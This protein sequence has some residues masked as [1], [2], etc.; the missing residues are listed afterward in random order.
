MAVFAALPLLKNSGNE[1]AQ[2]IAV[3]Q[4]SAP[5]AATD[6]S[7]ITRAISHARIVDGSLVT[8]A[9]TP[10]D[11]V[12]TP[13]GVGLEMWLR[14]DEPGSGVGRY[15]EVRWLVAIPA[16][17]TVA[18]DTLVHLEPADVYGVYVPSP[19]VQ[20]L[21][22]AATTTRNEAAASASAAATSATTAGAAR[23]EAVVAKNA[24]QAVGTTTDGV[25]TGV[26]G[27]AASTF[28][29]QSDA[30][31]SATFAGKAKTGRNALTGWFHVVGYGA[32]GDGITDDYAAINQAAIDAAAAGGGLV[33]IPEGTYR[34]SAYLRPRDRVRYFGAGMGKTIIRPYQSAAFTGS[35]TLES[36][37]IRP[38]WVDLTIDGSDIPATNSLKGQFSEFMKDA[39]WLRVQCR[40]FTATGFGSDFLPGGRYIDC[41]ATGNGRGQAVDGPGMSGFGIGTGKYAV[42]DF[43][44]Q[45]CIAS[46]NTNYGIFFEK[47]GGTDTTLYNSKGGRVI[48]NYTSGNSYGIGGCGM[49]GTIYSDNICA[50]NSRYGIVLHAGSGGSPLGMPDKTATITGNQCYGNTLDGI[51]IDYAQNS[52][53]ANQARHLISSNKSYGNA[54]D[55]FRLVSSR[56]SSD[57]VRAVKVIGNQ[58][59]GNAGAGI[60]I[61]KAAN[62]EAGAYIADLH[63]ENNDCNANGTQGIYLAVNLTRPVVK[64][65]ACFDDQATKTQTVGIAT[66]AGFTLTDATVAENQL[67]GNKNAAADFSATWAGDSDVHGNRGYVPG[68]ASIP[69]TASPVIYTCGVTPEVVYWAGGA[70]SSVKITPKGSSQA[71]VLLADG[72]ETVPL[73]PG[74]V[75]EFAYSTVATSLKTVRHQ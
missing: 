44:I 34:I 46:G 15:E 28:R 11:V 51:H 72:S 49:E 30:R 5:Y 24:A 52:I 65:N 50:S 7:W 63:I 48:G 9:G 6:G 36:P 4:V 37:I 1:K 16:T 17:A 3:L 55:G 59:Y 67:L 27:N 29:V 12:A 18:I 43:L 2:G 22:D 42:E 32:A 19:E 68:W 61:V 70:T 56:W 38:E 8:E 58:F 74:D 21:L 31:L 23:D 73:W 10:L 66:V 40:N 33:Y 47:Q 35:G 26:D 39:L 20:T 75:V 71:T 69:L 64:G 45:G 13:S 41:V 53:P 62:A 14:I 60:S 54:R 25:M 57:V